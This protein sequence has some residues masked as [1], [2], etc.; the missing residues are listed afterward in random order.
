MINFIQYLLSNPQ[1]I[2]LTLFEVS[3]SLSIL[4]A[5]IFFIFVFY[6]KVKNKNSDYI[7]IKDFFYKE[8]SFWAKIK[9]FQLYF[10]ILVPN[11]IYVYNKS[12]VFFIL[13]TTF[14]ILVLS[15]INPLFYIIYI[16]GLFF[17]LSSFIFAYSYTKI[18]S[19][20]NKIDSV[21][22]QGNIDEAKVIFDFFW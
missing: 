14:I 10:F 7:I 22:F 5:N 3:Y 17:A 8:R 15:G 11:K 4:L 16:L 1:Y 2:L 9:I 12:S 18:L 13:L 19:F 21:Y 6:Y 20:K